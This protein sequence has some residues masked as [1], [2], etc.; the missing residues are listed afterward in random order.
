MFTENVLDG[1]RSTWNDRY[2][3]RER[4]LSGSRI[5]TAISSS[6][7]DFSRTRHSRSI[8]S[9]PAPPP[10]RPH[11]LPAPR[12]RPPPSPS[13]SSPPTPAESSPPI[14]EGVVALDVGC[15]RLGLAPTTPTARGRGSR[16]RLQSPSPGLAS[17]IAAGQRAAGCLLCSTSL[18][19][20]ASAQ[21]RLF[22]STLL[23]FFINAVVLFS[24]Y[25]CIDLRSLKGKSRT[26]ALLECSSVASVDA[27]GDV[28]SALC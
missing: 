4:T 11:R 12:L 5:T 8:C 21:S 14:E 24:F 17:V 20:P 2:T 10:I 18:P 26:L 3:L 23:L 6:A 16:P 19:L 28:V 7:S 15:P 22:H 13:E 25:R 9:A 27:C 1:Y